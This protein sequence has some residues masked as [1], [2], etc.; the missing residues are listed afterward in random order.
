MISYHGYS[1]SMDPKDGPEQWQYSFFSQV[2]DFVK[3]IDFIEDIRKRL[4]PAT[5][6]AINET[7]T[8]LMSFDTDPNPPKIPDS[9]W[10]VSGAVY[11]YL[12]LNISRRDIDTLHMSHGVGYP[13]FF[14]DVSMFDWKTG[15]PNARYR[16]LKLIKD[17]FGP[18]DTVIETEIIDPLGQAMGVIFFR[19]DFG[20]QAYRKPDGTKRLL[21]INKRNRPI[22]V[23]LPKIE[24]S[25]QVQTVDVATAGNPPRISSFKGDSMELS[26]FSISVVTLK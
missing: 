2:D 15:K 8:V 3:K 20:A 18:G 11:A 25:A 17:N 9:Y 23:A 19:A 22:R 4:S 10:N 12:Y 1:F 21:L 6:T 7:G 5:R 14:P 24:S 16:A 26:P 13:G